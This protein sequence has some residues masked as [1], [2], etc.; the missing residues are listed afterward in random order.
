M[1]KRVQMI[2][3]SD[4]KHVEATRKPEA[5]SRKPDL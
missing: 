3:S 2:D 4:A 1:F 5:E